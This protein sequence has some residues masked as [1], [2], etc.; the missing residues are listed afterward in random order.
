MTNDKLTPQE[1]FKG[2]QQ[3][4]CW[5]LSAESLRD[6]AEVIIKR[7]DEYLVPY[8]RACDQAV[9]LAMGRAYAEGETAGHAEI[10]ARTPN[11][12]PAQLFS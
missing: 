10:P 12:P 9:N 7:E 3:P 4:V 2:A 5:L 11:Y 8:L 6:A 1:I